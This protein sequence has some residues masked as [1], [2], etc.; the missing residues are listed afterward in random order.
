MHRRNLIRM[1]NQVAQ[2]FD[3]YPEDQGSAEV[4]K[5]LRNFWDPRMRR[6]LLEYAGQPEDDMHPLVRR[7]VKSLAGVAGER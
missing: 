1:A 6:Q 7:A 3:V 5:H 2:F 4:A